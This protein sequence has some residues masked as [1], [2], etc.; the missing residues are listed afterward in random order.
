MSE[1]RGKP[2]NT[3]K[4]AITAAFT[5]LVFVGTFFFQINLPLSKGYFNLGEAV[6]YV[7]ALSFGPWIAAFAGGIGSLFSDVMAGYTVFAPWTLVIKGLEGL[8][9]G[10]LF[11]KFKKIEK[12]LK[13][14]SPKETLTLLVFGFVSS[15]SIVI[16]GNAFYP[17]GMV[18]WIVFSAIMLLAIILAVY[19]VKVDLYKM[20]FSIIIGMIV[21]IMGYFLSEGFVIVGWV[22]ALSEIPVNILQC[23]VGLY[24]AVPIYQALIKSKVLEMVAIYPRKREQAE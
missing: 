15:A 23:L 18:I 16:F 19:Y 8:V 13:T 24:L 1:N 17:D 2:L 14:S 12:Q 4:I 7:T 10:L 9:V 20:T 6:I 21:M 22:G 11:E 3:L 5:A